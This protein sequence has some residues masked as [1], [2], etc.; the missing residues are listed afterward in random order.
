MVFLSQER[1]EGAA[2]SRAPQ[3]LGG[4]VNG[5]G[6]RKESYLTPPH[7]AVR[8]PTPVRTH[9]RCVH[10]L[11]PR[12]RVL[13]RSR[14]CLQDNTSSHRETQQCNSRVNPPYFKKLPFLFNFTQLIIKSKISTL[15]N[16]SRGYKYIYNGSM[17]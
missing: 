13:R 10:G 3:R 8:D 9:P 2:A 14:H 16:I 4:G 17:M 11:H 6:G 5:R 1:S 15:K 7:G 12:R